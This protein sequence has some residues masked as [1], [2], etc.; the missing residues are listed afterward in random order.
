MPLWL[1]GAAALALFAAGGWSGWKVADNACKAG[2]LKA[3]R[4][5][6]EQRQREIDTILRAARD[7]EENRDA[8]R[9]VTR[10]ITREVDRIVERPVYRNVCLD[11]DGLR[12]AN[13]ALAGA[14]SAPGQPDSAVPRSD[15]PG[16]R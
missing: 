14:S 8:I 12:A 16:G 15:A 6:A 11:A 4:L 1:Y 13:A 9:T 10:T 7:F 3:E 5:A 2:Q